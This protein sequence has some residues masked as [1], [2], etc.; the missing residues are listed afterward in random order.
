[1]IIEDVA[2]R[3]RVCHHCRGIIPKGEPCIRITGWYLCNNL[4]IRCCRDFADEHEGISEFPRKYK[5]LG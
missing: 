3:E 4:C 5:S 2:K 1:M